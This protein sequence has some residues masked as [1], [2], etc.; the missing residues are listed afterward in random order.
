VTQVSGASTLNVSGNFTNNAGAYLLLYYSGNT[1]T[2]GGTLTNNGYLRVDTGS[3]INVTGG[4][5]NV[6]GSGN[7]TGAS[8]TQYWLNGGT[9]FYN[10]NAITN[11]A[12]G[13]TV[14]LDG[15]GTYSTDANGSTV[16]MSH[17][18]G[19]TSAFDTLN[20]IGGTFGINSGVTQ[21]VTGPLTVN[22]GGLLNITFGSAM[23]VNGDLTNA[24][25]SGPS[26]GCG[27]SGRICLYNS[28][29]LTIAGNLVNSGTYIEYL[30][31]HGT[32]A[33]LN[34]TGTFEL[35]NGSTFTLTGPWAQ[36][37]NAGELTAGNYNFQSSTFQ[38]NNPV[39]NT[40]VTIDSGVNLTVGGTAL[41][42]PDGTTNSLTTLATNNGYFDMNNGYVLTTT[43][44]LTNAG[45]LYVDTGASLTIP[46]S[47]TNSSGGTIYVTPSSSSPNST[48]SVGGNFTNAGGATLVLGNTSWGNSPG[49]LHVAGNFDNAGTFHLIVGSADMLGLTNEVGGLIQL[50]NSTDVLTVTGA[51][52]FTNVDASGNLNNGTLIV[53][54]GAKFQYNGAGITSIGTTG[55]TTVQYGGGS[56][57]TGDGTTDALTTLNT[58]GSEGT[59][60]MD[61]GQSL[62][63]VGGL[64]NAGTLSVYSG[65]TLNATGAL[66]N[67]GAMNVSA[68]TVTMTGAL[69][70]SGALNLYSASTL[71]TPGALSNSG[72]MDIYD[73]SAVTT[74][75]DVTNSGTMNIFRNNA[76]AGSTLTVNGGFAAW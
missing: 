58:I 14:G 11:I 39:I 40:I 13:V 27:T 9:L 12:S 67:S 24:S 50:D 45:T 16:I 63:L 42:T 23:N 76:D 35:L 26:S 51:G 44:G 28:D 19:A 73:A 6:D 65:S 56:L 17:D 18:G 10:G 31:D 8:G 20:T 60:Q 36:L 74:G 53:E 15:Y 29:T 48:L 64:S 30:D 72:T 2:I 47:V 25:G 5:T 21:N 22:A 69:S 55:P 70:N 3:A 38:Y 71:T 43:G 61:N 62:S 4:L 75:S 59:F 54:G 46:G 52:G 33:G 34:N 32:A 49:T 37:T 7:L 68:S 1:A 57:I 41:I 66:S